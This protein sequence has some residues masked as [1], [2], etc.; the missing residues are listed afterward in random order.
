M[1]KITPNNYILC[2]G[3]GNSSF[4]VSAFDRALIS[5]G[6]SDYNLIKVSSILPPLSV[7][8]NTLALQKGSLLPS[9]FSA[10]Y[11]NKLGET[12]SASVAVGIPVNDNEIGVIMKYSDTVEKKE[13]E[14]IVR[15]LVEQAMQDRG[16]AIKN[17]V[18]TSAECVVIS[19]EYFCAFATVS[20]W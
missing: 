20:M 10:I 6:V 8:R 11:S 12:I 19:Q 9:A 5:A 7:E 1:N 15:H 2:S 18:S 17:I 3:I 16:I 13:S 4:K 14:S